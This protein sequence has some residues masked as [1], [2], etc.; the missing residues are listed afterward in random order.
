MPVL[1]FAVF[2]TAWEAIVRV[3]GISSA[4]LPAPAEVL[5]VL[6]GR[7]GYLLMH[8]AHTLLEAVVG[9]AVG[10]A[11]AVALAVAFQL[12]RTASLAL[13]PYAIALKSLPLV[14]L[15]PLTELWF[16]G[17]LSKVVMAAVISFF[18]ALVSLVQG[19]ASAN[20]HAVDLFATWSA[21][22]WQVLWRL[23]FPS[24]APVLFA[25]MKVSCAFAVAGAV[26]AEFVAS[27]KGIGF[28]LKSSSYYLNTD[29]TFAAIVVAAG[30]GLLF[31]GTVSVAERVLIPWHTGEASEPTEYSTGL[32]RRDR[33]EVRAARLLKLHRTHNLPYPVKLCGLELEVQPRVFS[34]LY[35]EGTQ[36]LADCLLD[37]SAEETVLDI[38]TG[39]GALGLLAARGGARTVAVDI[40][41]AAVRCARANAQRLG[42]SDR[43]DVREGD[44]F[45]P[46]KPGERFSLVV[47]NPPF[48]E[49]Q[50]HDELEAAILDPGYR[51]LR[52]FIS[53]V[54]AVL[55]P[56]G[57]VWLAFADVG[58]TQLLRQLVSAQ[59][60]Q[61]R[62]IR[63][64]SNGLRVLVYEIH[65]GLNRNL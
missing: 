4:I 5:A 50:P 6:Y 29:L 55:A 8:G 42:L 46:L 24:A 59:G 7:C 57:R 60:L 37:L 18:P 12:S 17:F 58:D 43:M 15:A 53:Q 31:F 56:S 39:T 34:P 19:F 44:L 14:A 35:G 3:S 41:A 13:Y 45:G 16:P 1:A 28:V 54:S 21:S 11:V 9:F 26:V 64:R 47:F 32:E 25:G 23:R 49:G 63:Q 61:A 22:K 10:L 51:T 2:V 38:G 65:P 48:M 36:L 27:D 33:Q 52:Q 40:S 30:I 62:I 20:P